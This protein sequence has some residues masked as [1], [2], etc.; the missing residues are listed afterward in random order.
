MVS[1][2]EKDIIFALK[3]IEGTKIIESTLKIQKNQAL[4]IVKIA[5]DQ[6]ERNNLK[7][8]IEKNKNYLTITDEKAS[9]RNSDNLKDQSLQ[10]FYNNG[11]GELDVIVL[12]ELQAFVGDMSYLILDPDLDTYYLMD[13]SVYGVPK[14]LNDL[15]DLRKKLKNKITPADKEKIIL[16]KEIFRTVDLTRIQSD[17]ETA[18]KEDKNFN[19]TNQKLQ[20]EIKAKVGEL[21]SVGD[22]VDKI[23]NETISKDTLSKENNEKLDNLIVNL[24]NVGILGNQVL[25]EMLEKRFQNIKSVMY[26]FVLIG[27]F[28]VLIALAASFFIVRQ[29]KANLKMIIDQLSKSTDEVSSGSQSSNQIS[30]TLSGAVSSQATAIQQIS[31]TTHEISEMLQ[32][33]NEHIKFTRDLTNNNFQLVSKSKT[34]IENLCNKIDILKNGNSQIIERSSKN[35]ESFESILLIIKTIEEKTKVIND[36]VFQTKLLSFNASVEAARAGEL[37]KGFSVVAEEVGNLAE[38]SG[39][40]SFEIN[41][42]LEESLKK[43][44]LLIK[45][46]DNEIKKVV[47]NSVENINDVT[48]NV[49]EFSSL[50]NKILKNTEEFSKVFDDVAS[51]SENQTIAVVEINKAISNIDSV[52]V[53]N[54][55]LS[56][57]LSEISGVL[58]GKVEQLSEA[59]GNLKNLAGR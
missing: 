7:S 43:V 17:F 12:N 4:E 24:S 51:A 46:A 28:A 9:E 52:T 13:G 50:N 14:V 5:D 29:I 41:S 30:L 18:I 49:E 57:E 38:L 35:S 1:S 32:R 27:L 39:K 6:E 19:D 44:S 37:G 3:E 31:V 59:M 45:K 33:S 42:L 16:L 22:S 15:S 11:S 26:R 20:T 10:K 8:M 23:V 56:S 36:I 55:K 34:L 58:A 2:F 54:S 40:A 48:S 47:T 25:R 21:S 53:G